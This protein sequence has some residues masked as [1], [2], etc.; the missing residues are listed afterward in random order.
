MSGGIKGDWSG[1][2]SPLFWM[3]LKK[4]HFLISIKKDKDTKLYYIM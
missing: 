1:V 3:K 4:M 2:G